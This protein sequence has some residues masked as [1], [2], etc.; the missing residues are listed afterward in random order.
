MYF[1]SKIFIF[2]KTN[3]IQHVY[4]STSGESSMGFMGDQLCKFAT[5]YCTFVSMNFKGNF[6]SIDISFRKEAIG[7]KKK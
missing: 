1:K 5:V 2:I 6:F 4:I 7:I 3:I